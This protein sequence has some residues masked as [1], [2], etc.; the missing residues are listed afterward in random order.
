MLEFEFGNYL[1]NVRRSEEG[2][3]SSR[4]SD[5]NRVERYEGDLD[6]HF[7][8]DQCQ[9]LLGRL[10]Y[11]THDQQLNRPPKHKIPIDGNVKNGSAT[12]KQ[13]V[14]LYQR[15]RRDT[16]NGLVTPQ[17]RSPAMQPSKASRAKQTGQWPEWPQPDD[18]DVLQLARILTPLVKFLHPNIISAVVE[19]NI[20]NSIKWSS[21]LDQLG[22]EP[23]IYLWEDSPCAF[24]GVRRYAG[25]EEIAQFRGKSTTS[26]FVPPNCLSLDDNDYPKHLWAFVFTGKPFRKKGPS[27]FQLAHLADHKEHNNRWQEEFATE[28]AGEPPLLF[29]LYTSAANTAYVPSNFL[30]PTDFAGTLRVLLLQKAYQLY[31]SACRL[32][33]PPL[34][35]KI[36]ENTAWHPDNFKW[37]EPVGTMEYIADF[38]EYRHRRI[39]ELI[40]KRS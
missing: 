11:S 31:G 29:G 2:T 4:I 9:A 30:K 35:E 39:D 28:A 5:C 7:D 13:A 21:K 27:G 38:L 36:G 8:N 14:T 3:I 6:E 24:P 26:N 22:I 34:I 12:L 15:F 20:R 25:S 16:S 17:S 18:D 37:D 19:D 33:P 23:R 10:T 1:R 32:A 40:N